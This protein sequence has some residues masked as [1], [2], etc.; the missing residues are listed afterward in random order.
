MATIIGTKKKD[1][2]NGTTDDDL[3]SAGRGD[4][5]VNGDAGNDQLYGEGGKD[6]ISGGLGNDLLDGGIGSDAL[7]G[8]DGDDRLYGQAGRDHYLAGQAVIGLRAELAT[9][10]STAAPKWT[11]LSS[12]GIG[13]TTRSPLS[14]ASPG[15]KTSSRLWAATMEPTR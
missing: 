10:T 12:P 15:S 13:P 1:K 8:D 4:D 5:V 7:S 9:T 3:I 11:P 14:M 6:T 2:L